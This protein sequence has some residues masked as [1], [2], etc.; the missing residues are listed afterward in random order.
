M[1]FLKKI[2]TWWIH[3]PKEIPRIRD[4]DYEWDK[5]DGPFTCIL[6]HIWEITGNSMIVLFILFIT[7]PFLIPFGI[8]YGIYWL[9]K[10]ADSVIKTKN[11]KR[12]SL[13]NP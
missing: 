8:C 10:K 1:T 13:L 2:G 12:Q 4:N 11:L 6:K 9:A 5:D 7:W 3:P